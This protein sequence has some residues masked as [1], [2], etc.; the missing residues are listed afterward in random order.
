MTDKLI[1]Q[2]FPLAVY[3]TL[4]SI[5]FDQGNSSLMFVR[6]PIAHKK[7]FIPHFVPNGIQLNFKKNA[8]GIAELFFYD[9]KDWPHVLSVVDRLEGFSP[10]RSSSYFYHRTLINVR[11]LPSDYGDDL[12]ER[13]LEIDDRDLGIPREDWKF[14]AVAAWVYSNNDANHLCKINLDSFEN[15]IISD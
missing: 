4:R 10:N 1:Y 11:I 9:P 5:P 6:K 8:C 12:Y 2:P 14:P 15:P 7:C 13:G 3:G